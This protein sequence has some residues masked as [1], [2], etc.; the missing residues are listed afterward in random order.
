MQLILMRHAIA[1]ER[2]P[3]WPDDSLR[4]LT[5]EGE[6]KHRLVSE[7]LRRMGIR[8]DELV[9]SPLVR[10][11]QSAEITA[12][13]YRWKGEIVESDVLGQAFSIPRVCEFLA[14]RDPNA[15]VL[16]VGH[17]PDLSALAARLLHSSGDVEIA[18]KKSGVLALDLPEGPRVGS[19]VLLYFLKPSHLMRLAREG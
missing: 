4:P 8:F 16:A 11:G 18:F 5:R 3:R 2:G 13:V 12:A 17:E 9:S 10:A 6:R 14:E 1:E 15:A 7:V 19:G